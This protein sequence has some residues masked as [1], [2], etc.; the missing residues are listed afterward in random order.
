M[1]VTFQLDSGR[2]DSNPDGEIGPGAVLEA[3]E[4]SLQRGDTSSALTMVRSIRRRLTPRESSSE[5]ASDAL[6]KR[7]QLTKRERA[8]LDLLPDATLSQKDI[9]RSLGITPNTLKTHLRS[10]YQ[11]LGAH[12]RGEAIE[13]SEAGRPVHAVY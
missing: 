9:A 5:A 1:T 3:I 13:R 11:K 6:A 4:E 7:Y 12:S 10:L 8:T 2:A